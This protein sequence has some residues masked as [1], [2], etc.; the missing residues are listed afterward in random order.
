MLGKFVRLAFANESCRAWRN[1]ALQ[2]ISDDLS[3]SGGGQF[4]KFLQ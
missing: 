4:G 1:H 2:A 3:A